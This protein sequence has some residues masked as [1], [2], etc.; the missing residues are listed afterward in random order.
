MVSIY[1]MPDAADDV[2]GLANRLHEA[3]LALESASTSAEKQAAE[4]DL[5]VAERGLEGVVAVV[6]VYR[7]EG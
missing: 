2:A 6:G 1:D 3:T 4:D 5:A 7:G